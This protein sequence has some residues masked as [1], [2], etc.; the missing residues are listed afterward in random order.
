MN[1]TQTTIKAGDILEC[2]TC[3]YSETIV[4]VEVIKATEKTVTVQYLGNMSKIGS[5]KKR[6]T[7]LVDTL[8]K[9]IFLECGFFSKKEA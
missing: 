6:I 5:F 8:E 4:R 1:N 7:K 9:G 3:T 2:M